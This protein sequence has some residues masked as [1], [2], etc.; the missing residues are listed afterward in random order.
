MSLIAKNTTSFES[1]QGF[2]DYS[3]DESLANNEL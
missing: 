2:F 3:S 1:L